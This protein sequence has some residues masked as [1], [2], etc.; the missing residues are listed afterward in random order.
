MAGITLNPTRL[1]GQFVTLE[2]IGARFGSR[3]FHASLAFPAE[4]RDR[5]E[6]LS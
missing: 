1:V 6:C 2:T 4:T 3:T 5:P